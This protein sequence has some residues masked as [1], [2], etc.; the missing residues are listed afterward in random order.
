M[1]LFQ[2]SLSPVC[3]PLS[4]C[5]S[6]SLSLSLICIYDYEYSAIFYLKH[7]FY[8]K[9]I[10]VFIN[11]VIKKANFAFKMVF[12]F[13]QYAVAVNVNNAMFSSIFREQVLLCRKL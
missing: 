4:L 3:L 9:K 10:Q 6:V 11:I 13:W 7:T 1:D 2:N 8:Y 5:L 12:H